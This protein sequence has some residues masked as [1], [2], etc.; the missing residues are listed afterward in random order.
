MKVLLDCG[1]HKGHAISFFKEKYGLFDRIY[2]FEC[3]PFLALKLQSKYAKD[4]STIICPYAI[5]TEDGIS[6]FFFGK[7]NHSNSSS[8][9]KEKKG[10]E[11][12]EDIKVITI[13]FSKW[14]YERFSQSDEIVLKMDIEGAEYPV[15]EHLVT[16]RAISLVKSLYCEWHAGR[17]LPPKKESIKRHCKLVEQ[18]ERNEKIILE[19][20]R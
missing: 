13:D 2:L 12:N 1:A 4:F 20:W 19:P 11:K 14:L 9:I 7:K 6:S 10:V 3:N 18:L 17:R 8:L 15:L 16:T 5:W